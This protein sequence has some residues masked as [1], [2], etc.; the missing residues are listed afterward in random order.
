MLTLVVPKW[1]K[2]LQ[3]CT[4][5]CYIFK[6]GQGGNEYPRSTEIDSS[7]PSLPQASKQS[8]AHG[9][10]T[11][12]MPKRVRFDDSSHV[13]RLTDLDTNQLKRMLHEYGIRSSE[14]DEKNDIVM[15]LKK[16]IEITSM[17]HEEIA[18]ECRTLGVSPR[19]SAE[20]LIKRIYRG[21]DATPKATAPAP[22]Q[23]PEEEQCSEA[24]APLED[25]GEFEPGAAVMVHGLEAAHM[26]GKEGVVRGWSIDR[27]LCIVEVYGRPQAF[28]PENLV[29]QWLLRTALYDWDGTEEEGDHCLGKIHRGEYVYMWH[30]QDQGWAGWA[31][32]WTERCGSGWFPLRL[33]QS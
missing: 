4:Y 29:P 7:V 8:R 14:E 13:P 19:S 30:I 2:H 25:A 10:S 20:S 23:V 12:S 9:S 5:V 32:G 1:A 16:A 17:S 18:K 33:C 24:A 6:G 22:V 15:M 26:N 3:V 21:K 28:K 11:P 27:K 31:W